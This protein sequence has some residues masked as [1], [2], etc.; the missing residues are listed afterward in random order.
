MYNTVKYQPFPNSL[1]YSDIILRHKKSIVTSRKECDISIQLG[2]NRFSSPVFCA[3]MKSVLTPEI[4][5]VFDIQ[6]W[7][8]VYHRI[9]GVR[10][11]FNF[12][13]QNQ[14]FNQVSISI[15]VQEEDIAL[16]KK[17]FDFNHRVDYITVDVALSYN[18]NIK[19]IIDAV[20]KYYPDA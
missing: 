6:G 12:V 5:R 17:L 11:I 16:L 3:N 18:D 4:C 8:Y 9:D 1:N 10:D 19:Y 7:F 15:G 2:K 14:S 20:K 13:E